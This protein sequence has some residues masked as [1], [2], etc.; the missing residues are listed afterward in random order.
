M[1]LKEKIKSSIDSVEAVEATPSP[2][3]EV[4]MTEPTAGPQ[5][6]AEEP[7]VTFAKWFRLRGKERG[8]KPH[9]ATGMQAYTDTT[10]SRPIKEW[11][12]IFKN[13]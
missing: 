8:F 4:K 11:D 6:I 12:E 9:W 2:V 3:S 7:V 10:V 1:P 13:Y 5:V